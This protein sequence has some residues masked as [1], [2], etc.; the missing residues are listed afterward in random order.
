MDT[1]CPY[2]K[3]HEVFKLI[4]SVKEQ[5]I[6][7]IKNRYLTPKLKKGQPSLKSLPLF[8]YGKDVTLF[9]TKISH[10]QFLTISQLWK[11]EILRMERRSIY[12][13]EILKKMMVLNHLDR[14]YAAT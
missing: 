4:G 13:V 8:C 3:E 14:E 9:K 11:S 10:F 5:Q 2:R 7:G 1:M 6:F 12:L